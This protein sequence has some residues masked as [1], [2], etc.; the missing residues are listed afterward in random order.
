MPRYSALVHFMA[1]MGVQMDGEIGEEQTGA[2][3]V[4]V[5]A[6]EGEGCRG[7]VRAFRPSSTSSSTRAA[8]GSQADG[9]SLASP[10]KGS[11]KGKGGTKITIGLGVCKLSGDGGFHGL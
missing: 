4:W 3:S 7:D 10:A 9:Q 6:R 1:M 8:H 11:K 2:L 5:G